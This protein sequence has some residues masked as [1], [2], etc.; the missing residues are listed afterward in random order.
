MGDDKF[1]GLY[2]VLYC[3]VSIAFGLIIAMFWTS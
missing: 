2:L 1:Y 3:I